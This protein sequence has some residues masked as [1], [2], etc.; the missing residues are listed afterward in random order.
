MLLIEAV[1]KTAIHVAISCKPVVMATK[2]MHQ[3][4]ARG[5]AIHLMEEAVFRR[6]PAG[7]GD[8]APGHGLRNGD[9]RDGPID[10][11]TQTRSNGFRSYASSRGSRNGDS[12]DD[13]DGQKNNLFRYHTP[14][15]RIL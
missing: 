2:I 6:K 8:H 12:R 1:R 11:Q 14:G 7:Y 9:L 4:E 15:M 5:M 3:D 13:T 10:Y